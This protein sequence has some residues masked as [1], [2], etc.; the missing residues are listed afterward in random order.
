MGGEEVLLGLR[1]KSKISYTNV[2]L[3]HLYFL[4]SYRMRYHSWSS[5]HKIRVTGTNNLL[6]LDHRGGIET[7]W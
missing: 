2:S 6:A 5:F 4:G 3:R 7:L 1:L